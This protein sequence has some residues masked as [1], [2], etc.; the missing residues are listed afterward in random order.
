M[1]SSTSSSIRCIYMYEGG[2]KSKS[3]EERPQQAVRCQGKR[4]KIQI[5]VKV[6]YAS[7]KGEHAAIEPY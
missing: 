7:M 4:T 6:Y 2:H 1:Y 3:N 5:D